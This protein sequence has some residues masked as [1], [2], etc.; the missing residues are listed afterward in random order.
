MSRTA[1][2]LLP[3]ALALAGSLELHPGVSGAASKGQGKKLVLELRAAPLVADSKS[4][5]VFTAELKGDD[6]E[7][8]ALRCPRLEWD[9]GDGGQ[10]A[11]DGDC[12]AA[13]ED[14][15]DRHYTARHVFDGEGTYVITLRILQSDRFVA[16]ATRRVQVLMRAGQEPAEPGVRVQGTP[17]PPNRFPTVPPPTPG[18]VQP[19][20]AVD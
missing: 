13:S 15:P 19:S 7:I 10:D 12:D 20:A 5:I 3:V 11:S 4:P 17:T 8:R 1:R 14:I 18:K 16:Q 9:W 6:H 2:R